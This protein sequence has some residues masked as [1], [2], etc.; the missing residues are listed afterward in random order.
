MEF[1]EEHPAL[2]GIK[3]EDLL[4][5]RFQELRLRVAGGASRS[6][7]VLKTCLRASPNFNMIGGYAHFADDLNCATSAIG[8]VPRTDGHP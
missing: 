4:I 7:S 5:A 2:L 6:H 8:A 1:I 3:W